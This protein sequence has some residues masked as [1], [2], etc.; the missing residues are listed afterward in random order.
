[1]DRKREVGEVFDPHRGGGLYSK[2]WALPEEPMTKK[3]IFLSLFFICHLKFFW[4]NATLKI[5][6]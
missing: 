3:Y 1:M 5:D 6:P 2:T 4:Y